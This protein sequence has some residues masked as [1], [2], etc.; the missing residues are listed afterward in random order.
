MRWWF[1]KLNENERMIEY[2]YSRETKD[3]DGRIVYSKIDKVA[4]MAKP[5]ETDEGSKRLETQS[6]SHFY[7]QVVNEGFPDERY[8]CCG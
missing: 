7:G 3:Y 4:R 8:V 1:I 5:S 2:A 6:L